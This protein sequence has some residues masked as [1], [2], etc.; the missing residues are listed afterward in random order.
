MLLNRR[1]ILKIMT[2][3][4]AAK[5]GLP[6]ASAY[7]AEP[8]V[9]VSWGGPWLDAVKQISAEWEK[10]NNQQVRWEPHE[11]GTS[12]AIITKLRASWPNLDRNLIHTNDPVAHTMA[13]EGWLEPLDDLPSIKD[14]PDEFVLRDMDDRVIAA[15]H[16][17]GVT[18]WGYRTDLVPEGIT[19]LSDLLSPKFSGGVGLRTPTLTSGLPLVTLA[20]ERGGSEH[21]IDPAFDFLKELAATRKVTG[22]FGSA[23]DTVNSVASGATA[24][25]FGSLDEWR[26][27]AKVVPIK[28]LNRVPNGG[29]LKNFYVLTQIAVTKGPHSE[30][31]KQLV[32]Y[33]IQPKQDARYASLVSNAPTNIKAKFDNPQGYF[34]NPDEL[35]SFGY[36]CDYKLMSEKGPEWNERFNREIQP[37]LR[38]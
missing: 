29:G 6:S 18:V 31:T 32:E 5:F 37:L 3:A 21:N 19:S 23:I 9:G 35:K 4:P 13:A 17:A 8:I 11:G 38:G 14:M 25:T 16:S 22:V 27:L 28:I 10:A 7:A 34:L 1:K 2:L 24:V 20:L 33:L 36:F 15:P 12:A 30:A 26:Q